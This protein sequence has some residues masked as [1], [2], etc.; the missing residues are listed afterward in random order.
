MPLK[1]AGK[2]NA[3]S[4]FRLGKIFILPRSTGKENSINNLELVITSFILITSLFDSGVM[5]WGEVR[6]WSSFGIKGL[7]A[8][9][10]DY[11]SQLV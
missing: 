5:P 11:L 7:K 10:T 8:S 9:F 4:A 6:C 1:R 2:K 3:S